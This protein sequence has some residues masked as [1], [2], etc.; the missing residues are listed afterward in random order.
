MNQTPLDQV[1][2]RF[3]KKGPPYPRILGR[4]SQN[5][6]GPLIIVLCA[7]HGNELAGIEAF[8]RLLQTLKKGKQPFDGQLVGV[9]GD[10]A[11]LNSGNGKPRRYIDEDLNRIWTSERIAKVQRAEKTHQENTLNH[12]EREMLALLKILK[13]LQRD[14]HKQWPQYPHAYVFEPHTTSSAGVPFLIPYTSGLENKVPGVALLGME[15]I[16]KNPGFVADYLNRQMP[17]FYSMGIEGGQHKAPSSVR[18]L[19]N[20]LWVILEQMGNLAKLDNV[21][22]KQI[23]KLERQLKGLPKHLKVIGRLS[24]ENPEGFKLLKK[25][26]HNIAPVQPGELI[27]MDGPRQ[28]RVPNLV[29]KDLYVFMLNQQDPHNIRKGD[30][31]CFLAERISEAESK[32][33]HQ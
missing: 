1:S 2:F 33:V 5:R 4:Y 27:A 24:I 9:A 12:E 11:A 31:V 14:H 29:G 23:K 6:P 28:V 16:E 19:E 13:T 18:N 8:D 3:G 15:N 22:K 17:G 26:R 30:D 10:L 25:S 7:T 32:V 21:P 20:I